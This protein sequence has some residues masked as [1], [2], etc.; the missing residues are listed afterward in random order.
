MTSAHVSAT[1][2]HV[3]HKN[4]DAPLSS[5]MNPLSK[6]P[7][8]ES[9]DQQ[10]IPLLSPTIAY[11]PSGGV[12][13]AHLMSDL[14]YLKGFSDFEIMVLVLVLRM[15][16]PSEENANIQVLPKNAVHDNSISKAASKICVDHPK[17]KDYNRPLGSLLGCLFTEITWNQHFFGCP[18]CDIIYVLRIHSINTCLDA[19]NAMSWD[20]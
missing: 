15:V 13:F 19:P 18:H 5:V 2:E 6:W 14:D 3:N 17:G 10:F 7:R 4:A 20:R 8:Q 12:H 1:F 9:L 16:N 11:V